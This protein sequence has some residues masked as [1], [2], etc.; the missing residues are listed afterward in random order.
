MFLKRLELLDLNLS[1][2]G[3][4]LAFLTAL[5]LLWVQTAAE[6]AM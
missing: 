4:T 5:P 3:S 6:R 2:N 1:Q